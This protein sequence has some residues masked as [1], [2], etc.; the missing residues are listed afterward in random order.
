MTRKAYLVARAGIRVRGE[1]SHITWWVDMVDSPDDFV[2]LQPQALFLDREAAEAELQIRLLQTQR[3]LN[4]F[5]N[6]PDLRWHTS[7]T[8]DEFVAR[9]AALG[10][11]PPRLKDGKIT[12]YGQH[13]WAG[14]WA[15]VVSVLPDNT[16]RV[17]WNLL[18]RIESLGRVVEIELED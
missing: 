14:W 16:F 8:V 7:L 4:P 6:V 1:S 17:V 11:T 15:E 2:R 12:G 3:H 9:I 5:L 13:G 10:V 18:D